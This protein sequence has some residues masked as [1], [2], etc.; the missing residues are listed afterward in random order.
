MIIQ[1][2]IIVGQKTHEIPVNLFS[3]RFLLLALMDIFPGK[4]HAL[5]PNRMLQ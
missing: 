4:L 5:P 1:K 3:D 2:I